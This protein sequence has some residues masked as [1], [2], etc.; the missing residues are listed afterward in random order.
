MALVIFPVVTE[1]L[2][3]TTPAGNIPAAVTVG[4]KPS[5]LS[6]EFTTPAVSFNTE[7]PRAHSFG[8]GH[9]R[10]G[11]ERIT[12]VL[13]TKSLKFRNTV[14]EGSG[15]VTVKIHHSGGFM[16]NK[17]GKLVCFQVE[18][19]Y[20]DEVKS[21]DLKLEE[22]NSFI[23]H[24]GFC[25]PPKLFYVDPNVAEFDGFRRLNSDQD[26]K[27]LME[28][29]SA[30]KGKAVVIYRIGVNEYDPLP[31]PK[32]KR[33]AY[34]DEGE[35]S[36]AYDEDYDPESYYS[37]SD[38]DDESSCKYANESMR[39]SCWASLRKPS[40]FVPSTHVPE[41]GDSESDQASCDEL[42]EVK[43][44]DDEEDQVEVKTYREFN[45]KKEMHNPTF[46]VTVSKEDP[47]F[48]IRT[49]NDKHT[50]DKIWEKN[51]NCNSNIVSDWYLA[52]FAHD[53]RMSVG[54]LQFR[55][56][57]EK[58]ITISRTQAYKAKI[59]ALEKGL[60]PA[61]KSKLP[62]VSHRHCVHHLWSN[63]KQEHP[64]LLPKQKL[65]EIV[66]S[67]YVDEHEE[68]MAALKDHDE[69]AWRKFWRKRDGPQLQQPEFKHKIGRPK[70]SR[71]EDK[72]EP[73]RR[74]KRGSIKASRKKGKGVN[75]CSNCNVTG[76]I[77]RRCPDLLKQSNQGQGTIADTNP[78]IPKRKGRPPKKNPHNLVDEDISPPVGEGDTN[79][80]QPA[81]Q[82]RRGR[83]PTTHS[84]CKQCK[85]MGHTKSICL[86]LARKRSK[87][88]VGVDIFEQNTSVVQ[89]D[90]CRLLNHTIADCPVRDAENWLH[91]DEV[92][93]EIF[94]TSGAPDNY[95][96]CGYSSLDDGYMHEGCRRCRSNT[97]DD[98]NCPTLDFKCDNCNYFGHL[99]NNCPLS[100]EELAST[101]RPSSS[102]DPAAPSI[103]KNHDVAEPNN[104][105]DSLSSNQQHHQ[106]MDQLEQDSNQ[107]PSADERSPEPEATIRNVTLSGNLDDHEADVVIL[108][109][110]IT[111][112]AANKAIKNRKKSAPST[113]KRK[114]ARL[115]V[116]K[117]RFDADGHGSSPEKAI[118]ILGEEAVETSVGRKRAKT[119]HGANPSK[120]TL[121]TH[122][123]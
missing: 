25:R 35:E 76:H 44:S 2:P 19:D 30:E 20:F 75:K 95:I 116:V 111:S 47:T 13:M 85:Q 120:S 67:S 9:H 74:N 90:H 68:L 93:E 79:N 52:D 15:L 96:P 59:K 72:D 53:P 63:F 41:T 57:N 8:S 101:F 55:V 78:P 102:A 94:N 14:S 43:G 49:L 70:G 69:V 82:K 5:G 114:S 86:E 38:S 16:T 123:I 88:A 105:D 24:I 42:H 60:L 11:G 92:L 108:P 7:G 103:V 80:P 36:D 62:A 31:G 6:S 45:P 99:R 40:E 1:N 112:P 26:L 51:R 113:P 98:Y 91:D 56:L 32:P 65:F 3:P 121:F 119:F 50:C 104:T 12:F 29:T 10:Y 17:T 48:E 4:Q 117:V 71:F 54:T 66:K 21:E 97:H 33:P 115:A 77:R 61:V 84:K 106:N 27:S 100:E 34:L 81:Q 64:G 118:Q 22:V 23:D 39:T 122:C 89:C 73:V 83:P 28:I 46:E 107:T 18:V 37:L 58:K 87:E 109:T 110:A